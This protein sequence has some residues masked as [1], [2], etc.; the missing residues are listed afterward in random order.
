M[1]KIFSSNVAV[2][3][4]SV[5]IA[6]AIWVVAS[7][8]STKQTVSTEMSK[9][10]YRI[11]I[12]VL[13]APANYAITQDYTA[14]ESIVLKGSTSLLT[15]LL[16]QEIT[17]SI[18][19]NGL[20]EGE[21]DVDINL[22]YPAGLTVEA[23][24]PDIVH[25]SMVISMSRVMDVEVIITEQP[26]EATIDPVVV[27]QP[28][29]VLVVGSR[30]TLEQ[31]AQAVVLID[32]SDKKGNFE[33]NMEVKILDSA[34]NVVEGVSLQPNLIAVTIQLLP[35]KEVSLTL[36]AALAIPDGW[37]LQNYTFSPTTIRINGD[38]AQLALLETLPVKI[39]ALEIT[40]EDK[41][42][43]E[44]VKSLRTTIQLPEGITLSQETSDTVR[45][46]LTL[47]KS[48]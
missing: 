26:A 48:E 27:I 6:L 10:F 35:A 30:S 13:N 7:E 2:R 18:D 3:I 32:L 41:G 40:T 37:V 31:V 25:V 4:L 15:D 23:I 16:G 17:A 28:E 39:S 36:P 19:L 38:V 1:N 44:I 20:T 42:N 11:P 24:Q 22:R 45:V 33:Q 46:T 14:V 8:Q 29:T 21:H 9:N 5:L 12:E 47:K 43:Q 34:G